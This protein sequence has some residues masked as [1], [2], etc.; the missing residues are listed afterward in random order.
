MIAIS[1]SF[2]SLK[3]SQHL[4]PDSLCHIITQNPTNCTQSHAVIMCKN[5]TLWLPKHCRQMCQ[6]CT[7]ELVLIFVLFEE[8]LKPLKLGGKNPELKPFSARG[9]HLQKREGRG[10][11]EEE[12]RRSNQSALL[13]GLPNMFFFGFLSITKNVVSIQQFNFYFKTIQ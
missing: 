11:K 10:R 6:F 8:D 1:S 7:S 3:T 4:L 13:T 5:Q 12:E 9:M 2:K